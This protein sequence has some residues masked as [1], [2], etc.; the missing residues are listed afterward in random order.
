ME[1]LVCQHYSKPAKGNMRHCLVT[2]YIAIDIMSLSS[3]INYGVSGSIDG[4]HYHALLYFK[5]TYT[6]SAVKRLVVDPHADVLQVSNPSMVQRYLVGCGKEIG[7]WVENKKANTPWVH[8][9]HPSRT[10]KTHT[11][12][13]VGPVEQAP[14]P[15]SVVVL[16]LE[17]E[18]VEH[19]TSQ[20]QVVLVVRTL[21]SVE[22]LSNLMGRLPYSVLSEEGTKVP[23]VVQ[24]LYVVCTEAPPAGVVPDVVSHIPTM[25]VS[26]MGPTSLHLTSM[27]TCASCGILLQ[28]GALCF[29]CLLMTEL[30]KIIPG[31][32][33]YHWHPMDTTTFH[34]KRV[35]PGQ[36]LFSRIRGGCD[37]PSKHTSGTIKL[38]YDI[39]GSIQITCS[40]RATRPAD[41]PC[42]II[43]NI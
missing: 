26:A 25:D 38:V 9:V 32:E 31:S 27:D 6:P 8:C 10:S 4:R 36:C 16:Q 20:T 33:E 15:P 19:Y 29:T 7:T 22:L 1:C 39:K 21:P 14:L 42:R 23:W 40:Y 43:T 24:N 30:K 17:G 11:T 18:C 13:I 12:W 41:V 35:V 34:L 28:E 2:S 37:G 5:R 3:V